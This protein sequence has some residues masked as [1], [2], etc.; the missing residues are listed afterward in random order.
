MSTRTSALDA[1]VFGVDVHHGDIR[2]RPPS[3]A[4]VVL[5]DGSVERDVVSARKLHRLIAQHEPR[6]VATDNVYELAEDKDALVRLLR[7]LPHETRLVQ[8]TGAERPEPLSRVADRHGV[9]Y[10]KDPMEEA[11]AAA[12]L[13]A[14]NVGYHV[15]AFTQ[16]TRVKVS[17]GRS[18]GKGGWS[19]DRFTR[20][21]H[22]AVRHRTREIED[23]LRAAG[24][25]Y[26]LD[27][28]E[29]YGGY[30]NATFTVQAHPSDIPVSAARSGD[31]RVEIDRERRDGIT[32][33]PLA[34]RRDY[35][36]V[37]ID[38]GTTTAVAVVGID[39][40]LLDVYSTRTDDSAGV[41]EW[42]IDRGRP[43]LV[44]ADVTPMP[45]TVE[46]FRRSFDAASWVPDRDL[47]IDRKL[48]RTREL[49]YE[50]DHERDAIAAALFAYDDHVSQFE[51]I[52]N[53]IPAE[54]DP[55]VVIARVIGDSE[56]VQGVVE[57]MTETGT[58]PEEPAP[59]PPPEPSAEQRRIRQLEGRIDRLEGHI[60]ELEETI[61]QKDHRIANLET[62][63]SETRKEERE[64]IRERREVA[65]LRRTVNRLER[66]RDEW[67]AEA[68]AR[69]EKLERLK[70]LWRL[71]HS[72]ISDVE[73]EKRGLVVCKPIDK[74]TIDA[75]EAA[76]ES[77]GLA[78]D[79]VIFLRDASGA[80]ERTARRLVEFAPQVVLT[81]GG[82]TD[83]ADTVLFEAEIPVGP[84][85][86]VAM[87][88]VDELVVAR[89][90]DVDEVIQR[91][92]EAARRRRLD[93]K[94]SMVDRVIS[95]HRAE[96]R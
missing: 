41:I 50:N 62:E 88:E 78:K 93:E 22:G 2:G 46:K 45:E 1:T 84:A 55:D 31:I 70:A 35:V 95:E 82:L 86:Q 27:V 53:R 26:D 29:K 39:G 69:E 76:H 77:F 5:E 25:E 20:R 65:K 92:E 13:A 74:F 87:Q 56:S 83:I 72:N 89:E 14:A 30:A 8:V 33:E 36:I 63:L 51:R 19:E 42:I 67:E 12:R 60:D 90:S 15:S 9:P 61:D 85:D 17:R 18:T 48:H 81:D 71:D 75:I 28:T 11:E 24:L 16:T 32:F 38:P 73:P 58:E 68:E 10:G 59:T 40:E 23:T 57:S 66:D 3:Y 96:R 44:A 21:I 80:G 37:G 79:D 4:I 6:L 49:G 91:W 54:L 43:F 52:A 7:G 64:T 47:P 34:K 94:A